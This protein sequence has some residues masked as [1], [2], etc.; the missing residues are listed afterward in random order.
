MKRRIR[1]SKFLEQIVELRQVVR[2]LAPYARPH[3]RV[4]GAGLGLT[5][6]LIVMRLFQPWPL[7]WIVDALT[8]A[9]PPVEIRFAVGI[10]LLVSVA[11]GSVEFKQVMHLTGLGNRIVFLL[12]EDLFRHVMRQPLAFLERKREG[13]ILTRIVY[14]TSRLRNGVNYILTRLVQTVLIFVFTLVIVLWVDV[15]LTALLAV[16]GLIAFLIMAGGS[17][18]VKTA[19][20]K[21]RRREGKLAALVAEDLLAARE[22]QTFRPQLHESPAFS[23]INAQTLKQESKVRRLSAEMLLRVEIVVSV[24]IAGILLLGAHRVGTG[25]IGAGDLV[26][27]VFYATALYQPFFRFARQSARMGTTIASADRLQ[28]LLHRE[29]GIIDLP[30]AVDATRLRGEIEFKQLQVR[31]RKRSR[32]SRRYA[33]RS[34]DLSI[35]SGVRV[36]VIGANGAGKSTLLRLILRLLEPTSGELLIDGQP[37]SNYTLSSLRGQMS[38]VFQNSVLFGVSLRENLLLGKPDATDEELWAC[39]RR[40]RAFELV[41]AL[42]QRLDTVI[43]L[44]GGLLSS[45]ERQRIVIARAFMRDGSIWLLD[46]P[47]TGLDVETTDAMMAALNDATRGHTTFWVTHDP[48]TTMLLESVLFLADGEILFWGTRNEYLAW[49]ESGKRAMEPTL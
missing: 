12:R 26:L 43:R 9:E 38:V 23:R 4:L 13:E 24:G 32:A 39:L 31:Q 16:A 30:H 35:A 33:L 27:F 17:Y 1:P 45:G 21:N 42:P 7:K 14:D 34:V 28:K 6:I 36:S 10:F 2:L 20:R 46:E 44:R 29:P 40:A 49:L 22:V 25:G 15:V 37:V 11:A 3:R 19:A 8:G 41:E 47:T 18:R 48:R 5:L